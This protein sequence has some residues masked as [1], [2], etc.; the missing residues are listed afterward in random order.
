MSNIKILREKAKISQKELAVIMG[1]GQSTI[2]QWDNGEK[3]PKGKRL[4]KLSTV[5]NTTI[6]NLLGKENF[7]ESESKLDSTQLYSFKAYLNQLDPLT[8]KQMTANEKKQ[9]AE[10]LESAADALFF[11]DEI[12]EH[13]K[14]VMFQALNNS[15]WRAKEKIRKAKTEQ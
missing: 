7:F 2:S 3:F 9:L 8:N 6:D 12:D 15:F 11:D 1:V 10:I 4:I 14:E 13:D 5:L